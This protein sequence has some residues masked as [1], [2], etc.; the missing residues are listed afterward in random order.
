MT[1]RVLTANDLLSFDFIGTPKLSPN[2]EAVVYTV[3]IAD[4]E[5]NGYQS[6]LYLVKKGHA[7]LKL[8]SF[9]MK[10]SLIRDQHPVWSHDGKTIYFL[11]NRTEKT[12]VWAISTDGGEATQVSNF[13]NDVTS[14]VLSPNNG[15]LVCQLSVPDHLTE[16]EDGNDQVTIITRLRYLSNGTGF[17]KKTQH[18]SLLSLESGETKQLTDGHVSAHSPHF[19]PDG[20]TLIFLKTKESPEKHD[21]FND[22][23]SLDLSTL[24]ENKLYSGKGNVG[25][26][27][28]SPDGS[29]IA[30]TGHEG[31]EVSPDNSGIWVLPIAGGTANSLT[32][33]WDRPVGNYVG[34]DS[35][36][37][38]GGDSFQWDTD[39]K[40]LI[41][42]STEGGNCLL[43][44]ADLEGKVTTLVETN[45]G[46]VFS[47]D[48]QG[49][50][51]VYNFG[52]ALDLGELYLYSN[53]ETNRLTLHNDSLLGELDLAI[54]E[55]MT[56]Q[57]VDDWTI[58]GWVL[59]PPASVR[60]KESI[61]VVVEIHGGP[62]TAY[63]N[64]FHHEF[65][66]LAANGYA[67]VYTNPRGSQGYGREFTAACVGDWGQKDQQDILTGLDVALENY[68]VLDRNTHF[69]T[70]G[71]YGG[72][73]TNM[74][75]SHTNRFKAAVTQRCISNMYSF[76][77]TSDI[78]YFFGEKQL[79]DV[80]L[81]ED[82]DTVLHFSPIRYARNVKTPTCIIHSE[83]DY[84]C[85]IEQAEQWYVALR[86]LGVETRFVRFKGENHELSRSGKP[87]NRL[88]RL[89]EI[90][91]WFNTHR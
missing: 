30:F 68:P 13:D 11:S 63:G 90:L 59:L 85:P 20:K 82:E 69:V 64:A 23:Y 60:S 57:S 46:V 53:G 4:N 35:N 17:V 67:V 34:A 21:Y 80:D 83:E 76:F 16:S 45:E 37:D 36:L 50:D 6:S 62:H 24:K 55:K 89:N 19:P 27:A 54:P 38:S 71:S 61:P 73:M 47:F 58:E 29:L 52:T 84:R 72:F 12:Q 28:V 70:G 3:T 49:E 75:V 44:H 18:L 33:N 5:L 7:P 78:G 10:D 2:K 91:S 14:F 26:P 22:L 65:Q 8:T 77:G 86:R 41:F 56:Y 40:G 66:L 39:S 43:K 74:I 32:E 25:S 51:V 9:K 31:G 1:K 15:L 87:K 48:R 79:G 42:T 88:T 81:W